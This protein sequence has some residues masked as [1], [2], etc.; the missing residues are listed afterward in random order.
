MEW[1]ILLV[2]L[3]TISGLHKGKSFNDNQYSSFGR[4]H[5]V[6]VVVFKFM[7]KLIWKRTRNEIS[8]SWDSHAQWP[9][10]RR[11][12]SVTSISS[13]STGTACSS[14]ENISWLR[15]KWKRC[16]KIL[17]WET[18]RDVLP[19]SSPLARHR[20]RCRAPLCCQPQCWAHPPCLR[21]A[22]VPASQERGWLGSQPWGCSDNSFSSKVCVSLTTVA[23]TPMMNTGAGNQKTLVRSRSSAVIPPI[24][25]TKE[26]MPTAWFLT[27]VGNSS[28]V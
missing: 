19:L 23:M 26:Q 2:E 17:Y 16:F 3:H 22:F 7:A 12:L 18:L 28:A 20:Y 5:S 24:L 1:D 8:C 14:S 25:A 4:K 15:E 10:V 6:T 13:S 9:S 27:V 21:E 11:E